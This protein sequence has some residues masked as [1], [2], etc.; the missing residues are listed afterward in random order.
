MNIGQRKGSEKND[1]TQ[2]A[3][4]RNEKTQKKNRNKRRHNAAK[5]VAS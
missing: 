2:T 5:K 1:V 3:S 4:M